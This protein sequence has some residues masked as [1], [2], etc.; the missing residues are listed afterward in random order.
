MAAGWA[1][2][3]RTTAATEARAVNDSGLPIEVR[4]HPVTG[5]LARAKLKS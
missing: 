5:E 4:Y 2:L 1:G 3:N